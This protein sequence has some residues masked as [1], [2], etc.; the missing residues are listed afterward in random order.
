MKRLAHYL[1]LAT[2]LA[3]LQQSAYAQGFRV[4]SKSPPPPA[5]SETFI[6]MDGRFSIAL[7][8]QISAYAPQSANTPEG[9]VEGS[10][11]TWKTAEG[12]FMSGYIERPEMLESMSKQV[13]DYLH[14]TYLSSGKGKLIAETDISLGGHPGRELRI[15]Y[16]D[17]YAIGRLYIVGNRIYQTTAL[18]PINKKEQEATVVKIL[19]SFKLLSAADVDAEVQRRVA[20]ATPSP[21]PQEPVAKKLK[22]DAEDD[23]L[24]GKVKTVFTETENFDGSWAVSK[25]K[26]SSMSYYNEQGNLIKSV[27]YDYRGNPADIEVYGYLDGDR[28]SHS[29]SIQYEYDPPP[30]MMPAASGQPKPKYDPRY[31]YKYNYKYDDKGNL[32]EEVLFGSGGEVI[33]RTVNKIKGSQKEKLY[34]SKD[35]SLD[36][37]YSYTLDD[38][39]NEIEEMSYGKDGSVRDKYSYSYEYDANEN[40]VKRAASKWVTKDGKSQPAPYTVDYRTITYY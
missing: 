1:L 27:R 2:L 6:S 35:G 28:V 16:P 11:F 30:M 12:L 24:K 18:Y 25:R 14:N 5:G 23:G 33:T 9:R 22:S 8:R 36:R 3:I 10:V 13:L 37:K 20:E 34:Y 26:P 31:S 4:E 32:V 7:P 29:K 38:K 19:D 39:G 21:L 17:Q 40:W 15:E